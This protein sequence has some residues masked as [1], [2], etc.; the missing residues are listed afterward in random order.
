MHL[1]PPE[2]QRVIV[3]TTMVII[4][5]PGCL[6]YFFPHVLYVGLSGFGTRSTNFKTCWHSSM[7]YKATA[8][9]TLGLLQQGTERWAP[10]HSK[11]AHTDKAAYSNALSS[12][13]NY[14]HY[15]FWS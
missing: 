2:Q 9:Q 3:A 12:R 10:V 14:V 8:K 6:V 1:L 13:Q 15:L 7:L 5:P 11:P 4:R